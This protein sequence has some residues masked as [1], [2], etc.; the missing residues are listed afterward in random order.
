MTAPS[1]KESNVMIA[2]RFDSLTLANM[3]VALERS[4]SVLASG[5]EHMAR[6]HVA[7]NILKCARAGNVTLGALTEAGQIAASELSPTHGV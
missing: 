7:R 5:Q 2:G 1:E 6:R 3:E 4:C